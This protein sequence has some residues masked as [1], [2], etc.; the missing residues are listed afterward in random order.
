MQKVGSIDI[1]NIGYFEGGST[2]LEIYSSDNK[3][4]IR[5]NGTNIDEETLK[6]WALWLNSPWSFKDESF[7]IDYN[8][9][10]FKPLPP[11]GPNF[12]CTR[13]VVGF[14][15]TS[16]ECIGYGNTEEEALK[17]C[18]EL[19]KFVQETYNKENNSI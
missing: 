14:E 5:R 2:Y 13:T 7:K 19:N 11:G 8:T 1:E 4:F 10:G 15:F 17:N 18:K 12:V 3:T 9:D 16:A 6:E